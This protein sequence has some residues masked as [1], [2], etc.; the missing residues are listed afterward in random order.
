MKRVKRNPCRWCGE[1]ANVKREKASGWYTGDN[2]IIKCS[3]VKCKR[4]HRENKVSVGDIAEASEMWN[5]KNPP[6]AFGMP[7]IVGDKVR[8]KKSET[9][10][11]SYNTSIIRTVTAIQKS[12]KSSSGFI[13]EADAGEPCQHC[14]RYYDVP[15]S[16]LC[17]NWVEMVSP[18]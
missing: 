16:D 5:L 17:S 8:V 14:K 13:M 1:K 12:D 2:I 7:F 6:D 4:E 15:T 10:Q 9:V 11:L 3:D 18:K